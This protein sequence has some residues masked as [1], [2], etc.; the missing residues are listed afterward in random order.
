MRLGLK[1]AAPQER[2]NLSERSGNNNG[3]GGLGGVTIRGKTPHPP[4]RGKKVARQGRKQ[5]LRKEATGAH[6]SI[7]SDSE[8]GQKGAQLGTPIRQAQVG[9]NE[10]KEEGKRPEKKKLRGMIRTKWSGTGRCQVS[11]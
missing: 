2:R 1:W 8:K 7:T 5:G 11:A 10:E 9:L 6:L 3:G 4:G